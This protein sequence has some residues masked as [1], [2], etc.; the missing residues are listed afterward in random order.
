MYRGVDVRKKQCAQKASCIHDIDFYYSRCAHGA[1][2]VGALGVAS[3]YCLHRALPVAKLRF[4]LYSGCRLDL[5][6][7]FFCS[8]A[9][10][11]IKNNSFTLNGLQFIHL[12]CSWT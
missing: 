6:L 9:S 7:Y 12:H 5:S 2:L 10:W 8:G 1:A 3:P 11:G 4:F